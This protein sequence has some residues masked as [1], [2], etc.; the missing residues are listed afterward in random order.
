VRVALVH[1]YLNQYGGAERVLEVLHELYPDAPV[2]TSLFDRATVPRSFRSWDI[3]TSFLQRIPLSHRIHRALLPLYPLAFE[4]FDLHEYDVVLSNSSAWAKGVITP[5]QTLHVCYC[6]SPMRWAWNYDAYVQ[7]EQLRGSARRL[8]PPVIHY[9]RIWDVVS[10]Q[11]VDRFIGISRVVRDRIAK[12][13]RREADLIFPP[14][15]AARIPMGAERSDEYLVVSRLIPYKRI[16]LAVA[17][18]TR[19]G[20]PLRVIG[21]GRDREKLAALAGPTVRFDGRVSDRD[22][23]TALGRCRAFIF[24]GEEDFGIAPVEA[25]AAG[26][27]VVAY[28]AGGALDTVSDGVSGRYFAPQTADALADTLASFDSA[29]FDPDA[30]RAHA[31]QFDTAA[32]KEQI[33]AY[34]ADAFREHQARVSVAARERTSV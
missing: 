33:Q 9:L 27:P 16:D 25:M 28:A 4:S 22:V 30:V 29:S 8:L 32:F 5:P 10:A 1:D 18:C 7:R 12:Y 2:Y 3:R 17:A 21:D 23:H 15:D 34:V 13:Y 26:R 19:L 20:V 11:R 31:M 24:P 6:L 14:V